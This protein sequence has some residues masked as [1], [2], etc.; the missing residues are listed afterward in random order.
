M[1]KKLIYLQV[2]LHANRRKK[3]HTLVEI[4]E[5]LLKL[6]KKKVPGNEKGKPM[7]KSEKS[8]W[9]ERFKEPI[10]EMD[11]AHVFVWDDMYPGEDFSKWLLSSSVV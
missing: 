1:K 7:T 4:L 6:A 11:N 2:I 3:E 5:R 10:S 9:Y 8:D